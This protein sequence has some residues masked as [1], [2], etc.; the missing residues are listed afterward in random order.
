[1]KKTFLL[2]TLLFL[3][4]AYPQTTHPNDIYKIMLPY[5]IV[6]A[7]AGGIATHYCHTKEKNLLQQLDT[8]INELQSAPLEDILTLKNKIYR[9]SIAKWI[10]GGT[11]AAGILA[12]LISGIQLY[13]QQQITHEHHILTQLQEGQALV[14]NY[15]IKLGAQI[16]EKI[17]KLKGTVL[18]TKGLENRLNTNNS[19]LRKMKNLAIDRD[20]KQHLSE[21]L[22]QQKQRCKSFKRKNKKRVKKRK[23]RLKKQLEKLKQ[24]VEE[25]DQDIQEYQLI[26]TVADYEETL[27]LFNQQIDAYLFKDKAEIVEYLA[28]QNP[29]NKKKKSEP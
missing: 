9:F 28:Q 24:T 19:T 11:T 26:K 12:A 29:A 22:E 1:M 25:I 8:L 17:I 7:I 15:K 3:L 2:P 14:M 4:F 23:K 5:G 10:C 21:Q 13:R 6:I 20:K 18:T 16:R 27:V